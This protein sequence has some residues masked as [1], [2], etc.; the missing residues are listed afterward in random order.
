MQNFLHRCALFGGGDLECFM[1]IR[2]EQDDNLLEV[3]LCPRRHLL[4]SQ[5]FALN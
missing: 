5:L 4:H 2:I 1:E 3:G